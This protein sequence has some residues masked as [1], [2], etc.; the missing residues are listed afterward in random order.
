MWILSPFF[1]F[2]VKLSSTE[3]RKNDSSEH[4]LPCACADAASVRID[5][6]AL[7][8]ERAQII[9]NFRDSRAAKPYVKVHQ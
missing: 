6:S 8:L 9:R 7:T 3:L 5:D 2:F 4:Q 1:Y